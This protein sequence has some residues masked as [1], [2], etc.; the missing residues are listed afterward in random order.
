MKLNRCFETRSAL[1]NCA[2]NLPCLPIA[3]WKEFML[4][5]NN[6]NRSMGPWCAAFDYR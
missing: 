2:L 4:T 6:A 1:K 5:H 3:Y